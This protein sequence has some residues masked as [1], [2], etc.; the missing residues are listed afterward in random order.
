MPLVLPAAEQGLLEGLSLLWATPAGS[1]GFA[2]GFFLFC[3]RMASVSIAALVFFFSREGS[4][5]VL[6]IAAVGPQQKMSR[7]YCWKE[8]IAEPVPV[9]RAVMGG[10]EAVQVVAGLQIKN[11]EGERK[12]KP[13]KVSLQVLNFTLSHRNHFAKYKH[14]FS[15]IQTAKYSIIFTFRYSA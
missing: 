2:L 4:W 7:G 11:G 1:R 10:I 12:K 9:G 14:V 15:H 5:L 13:T 6:K 3:F 8:V